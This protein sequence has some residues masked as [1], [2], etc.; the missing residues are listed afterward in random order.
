MDTEQLYLY[1]SFAVIFPLIFWIVLY[2]TRIYSI[3]IIV[4]ISVF[5]LLPPSD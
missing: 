4:Q 2:L 1:M 3:V 5:K